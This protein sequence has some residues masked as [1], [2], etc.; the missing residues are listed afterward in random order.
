MAFNTNL[1][2]FTALET[3]GTGAAAYSVRTGPVAVPD[4]SWTGWVVVTSGVDPSPTLDNNRYAQMKV[5]LA[6]DGATTPNIDSITLS[7]SSVQGSSTIT[8]PIDGATFG[9]GDVNMAGTAQ[10][11]SGAPLDKIEVSTDGGVTWNDATGTTNWTYLFAGPASGVYNL[12]SRAHNNDGVYE[13]AGAG[14]TITVDADKPVSVISYPTTG[15]YY[16]PN[17]L[18]TG[19]SSDTGGGIV[20]NLDIRIT[21]QGTGVVK[22]WTAVTNTGTNFSTWSYSQDGLLEDD[23]TYLIETRATDNFGNV[24]TAFG[25]STITIDLTVPSSVIT[26][27]KLNDKFKVED[28]SID[29]TATTNNGQALSKVDVRVLKLS[30]P[31]HKTTT[32]TAGK[33]MVQDWTTVSGTGSWS[34]IIPNSL[35]TIYGGGYFQIQ[36]RATN[37]V[38]LVESPSP[39]IT[40]L[41]DDKAPTTPENIILRDAT[42]YSE[43]VVV[44]FLMFDKSADTETRIKEYK[45]VLNGKESILKTPDTEDPNVKNLSLL[46]TSSQGAKEG[47]NNVLVKAID[48]VDNESSASKSAQVELNK[49]TAAISKIEIKNVTLVKKQNDEETTSALVKY[50]SDIP[51]STVV[52]WDQSNPEGS[53]AK[54]YTDAAPSQSHTA[55]L[56]DLVP[57][58]TYKVKIEGIDNFGNKISSD[59][60][61]F[62]STPKPTEESILSIIIQALRDAFSWVKRVM[63]APF[64]EKKDPYQETKDYLALRAIDTTSANDEIQTASI[65]PNTKM[66]SSPITKTPQ[67]VLSYRKNSLSLR[68][69]QNLTG[70]A[71][72]S[73]INVNLSAKTEKENILDSATGIALD[74]APPVNE[75]TTYK[76]SGVDISEKTLLPGKENELTPSISNIQTKEIITSQ[77]KAEYLITFRTDIPSKGKLNLKGQELTEEGNNISHSFYI[78]NLNSG[79]TIKYKITAIT[80]YDKITES[81]DQSFTVPA[82]PEEKGIWRIIIDALISA[83]SWFKN[84]MK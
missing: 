9:A 63:A 51:A 37:V 27:P 33:T 23:Q 61:S 59:I 18:A 12:K 13:T 84:L 55:I 56:S 43:G 65:D 4:G 53:G 1:N 50:S 71:L 46:L 49:E 17:L 36:S 25:S 81:T 8:S 60:Q 3:L 42:N 31:N 14:I 7:Y 47:S 38:N 67:I 16:S 30:D 72:N 41:I 48:E 34:Y 24:Q 70:L 64:T 57:D 66:A 77:D 45:I 78:D 39:G 15:G 76:L 29:G 54:I 10:S 2:L 20:A 40:I 74:K 22:D 26:S 35:F 69:N 73:L 83:F 21:K 79:D 75:K 11:N 44:L 62:R 19:T 32:D 52:Y 6:G 58:S 68:N 82:Q 28:R 80:Q 5:D